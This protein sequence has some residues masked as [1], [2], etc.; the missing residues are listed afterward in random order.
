MD[1]H[2]ASRALLDLT[3]TSRPATPAHLQTLGREDWAQLEAIAAQHGLEHLL[4]YLQ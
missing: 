1:V 3:G 4:N 2:V